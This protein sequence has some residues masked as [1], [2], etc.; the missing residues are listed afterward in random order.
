MEQASGGTIFLDEIGDLDLN[1]QAKLLRVLEENVFRRVGGLKDIRLDGAIIAASNQNLEAESRAGRFRLDLYYRL[2]VIEIVLPPLRERGDDVLLLAD[3]FISHFN[4]RLRK[5]VRGLTAETAEIFRSNMWPGNVR[6]LR[7]VIERAMI[8]EDGDEITTAYLPRNLVADD[9][10]AGAER[11]APKLLSRESDISQTSFRIPHEG[12]HLDE[13]EI[14]LVHQALEMSDG[15]QT[16]AARLLGISRD[17]LR[18]R[19]K[20][21]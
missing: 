17:R 19:L 5:R 12:I 18:Y 4:E 15:N 8:L 16:R 9:K 20:K 14:S 3:H 7:N 10:N 13:L 1:L 2:S 11:Q 21:E 6:E